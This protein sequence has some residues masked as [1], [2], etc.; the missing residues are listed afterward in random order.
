MYVSHVCMYVHMY[1]CMY[2]CMYVSTHVCI[3]T[4]VCVCVCVQK[5]SHEAYLDIDK[6]LA[7]LT[8]VLAEGLLQPRVRPLRVDFTHIDHLQTGVVSK[9]RVCTDAKGCR[10]I[11]CTRMRT[12]KPC[13][14]PT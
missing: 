10:T 3:R 8:H 5:S 4:Y 1:A 12:P 11:A 13:P 2:V 9:Y 7:H 14:T 6:V